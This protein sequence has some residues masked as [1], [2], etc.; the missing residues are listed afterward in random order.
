MYHGMKSAAFNKKFDDLYK[1]W[2]LVSM[3]VN[4]NTVGGVWRPKTKSYAAYYG[5]SPSKYQQK[6]NEFSKKGMRLYKIQAYGNSD[7]FAAIW[8]K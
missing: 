7:K 3:H 5:L 4:G 6:F 8:V 1:K 2:Q